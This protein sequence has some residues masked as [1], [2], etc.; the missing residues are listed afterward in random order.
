[1]LHGTFGSVITFT[2]PYNNAL[3]LFEDL[4]HQRHLFTAFCERLLVDTDAVDP[5]LANIMLMS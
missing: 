3:C 2:K 1:V 5:Q 4:P